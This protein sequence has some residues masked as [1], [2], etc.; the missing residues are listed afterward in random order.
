MEDAL[1]DLNALMAKAKEMVRQILHSG[2]SHLEPD[3]L[4]ARD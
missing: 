1:Q 3:L 2:R 4:F